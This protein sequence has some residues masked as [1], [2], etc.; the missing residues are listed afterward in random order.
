[1][2]FGVF[3][4]HWA[5]KWFDD[6]KKR[7]KDGKPLPNMY[8]RRFISLL[9]KRKLGSKIGENDGEVLNVNKKITKIFD[10]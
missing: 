3:I 1:M 10:N 9:L 6:A 4:F 7:K 8:Y 2:N 5:A